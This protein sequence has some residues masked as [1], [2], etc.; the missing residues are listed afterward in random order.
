[1]TFDD[2]KAALERMGFTIGKRDPRLNRKFAGAFM[3]VEWHEESELPTDDGSNGPWCIVGG[4][5]PA[6]VEDAFSVWEGER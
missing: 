6:L 2:K 3:V 4:D 5:L 1:M